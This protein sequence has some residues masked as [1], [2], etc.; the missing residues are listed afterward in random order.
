MPSAA[1]ERF[2]T[3][4]FQACGRPALRLLTISSKL[5]R[6]WSIDK[7]TS[8]VTILISLKSL[9]YLFYLCVLIKNHHF[10]GGFEPC[11]YAVKV[12]QLNKLLN[13]STVFD[14]STVWSWC[15]WNWSQTRTT[16]RTKVKPRSM[17]VALLGSGQCMLP[18]FYVW[19]CDIC[20]VWLIL[21][22]VS[23]G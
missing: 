19:Y 13:K 1:R 15:D 21:C 6:D 23:E 9:I 18:I 11:F 2:F 7:L 22:Y 10:S 16:K 12:V 3:L 20:D 14:W 4:I 5:E 8:V 17:K